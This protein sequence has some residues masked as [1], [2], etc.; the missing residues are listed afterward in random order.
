MPVEPQLRQVCAGIEQVLTFCEEWADEAAESLD[1]SIPM[2][3]SLKCRT[4]PSVVTSSESTS[5]FPRWAIAF[6]FAGGAGDHPK[7]LRIEVNVGRTGAVT[8]YAVLEPVRIAGSTVASWP[9]LHNAA[10]GRAERRP[11][12]RRT[13]WWRRAATS[14]PRSSSRFV[15][16]RPARQK[17]VRCR[18]SCQPSVRRAETP[19]ERPVR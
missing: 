19:L 18:S 15:N 1:A 6:K 9:R 3:S 17:R 7:L 11:R 16:R 13:S 5:K 14:S 8:P 2:V 12:R 4:R 10:G